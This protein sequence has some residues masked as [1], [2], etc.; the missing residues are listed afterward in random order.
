MKFIDQVEINVKS[1]NGGQGSNSFRREKHVPRGGPDGG[2]GGRG[3]DLVFEAVEKLNS[4]IDFGQKE[5]FFAGN[6]QGGGSQNKTGADGNSIKL[7]VPVGTIVRNLETGEVE[8]DLSE[9]G[10]EVVF[11][12][13]GKGGRGNSLF[14]NSINQA[15]TY[16]QPGEVGEQKRVQL[17]LKLMADVGLVGYPNA[18]KSTLISRM[19]AAKPKIAEYPFT[20]LTPSLGVVK[21][22]TG[23]SF[24]L[25][26]IPGIIKDAHK[27][28]GL[29]TQFLRHIERTACFIHLIDAS[30]FSGRDPLE[31]YKDIQY[32]LEAHDKMN[33]G[34]DGFVPLTSREQIVV[35]NKIDTMQANEVDELKARFAEIDV[36]PHAISAVAGHKTD[37]LAYMAFEMIQKVRKL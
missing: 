9:D 23:S 36:F 16:F 26:D 28:T 29:G 20:T 21:L 13:G 6:G 34:K 7:R 31:D 3:G 35:L 2:N 25:A 32:E 5:K 24:V 4:L 12:E 18:G 11:L 22:E 14:K 33:E 30:V 1:G 10:Q 19:S 8:L 17:E 27:G 37:D 15:P